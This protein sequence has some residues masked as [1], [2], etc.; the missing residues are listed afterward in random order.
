MVDGGAQM[1]IALNRFLPS[2]K[3]T[4]D[5]YRQAL[6]AG[7]PTYLID[8]EEGIPRRLR[9]DDPRLE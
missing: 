7:M 6:A 3:G 9:A 8:E 5:C 2:R 4:R 1:C